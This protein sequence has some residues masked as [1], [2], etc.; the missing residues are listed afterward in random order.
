MEGEQYIPE[1]AEPTLPSGEQ[2]EAAQ[3]DVTP[4]Q[5]QPVQQPVP[6]AFDPKQFEYKYKG[7]ANYPKDRNHLISL[8]SKGHSYESSMAAIK[9][10]QQR[11]AELEGRYKPYAQL[12]QYFQQNPQ[13]K[14]ELLALR[15][16][17]D[18]QGQQQLPQG[19]PPELMQKIEGFENFQKS[20]VQQQADQKLDQSIN[21]VK[22]K[23]QQ[24]DWTTD[25]GEGALDM[26]VLKFMDENKIFDFE[27]GFKAYAFDMQQDRAKAQGMQQQAQAQQQ[28][29][30]M[31]V[32]DTGT[33]SVT[34][35]PKPPPNPAKASYS[36][37]ANQAKAELAGR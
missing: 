37:L 3:A 9:Q 12:D 26:K 13:F 28:R 35:T 1:G 8:I 24:Y 4:G 23:Y 10:E 36:Q 21:A 32:V 11:I 5:G 25:D 2:G 19:L 20:F 15:Q 14:Q 31:G 16:K 22:Q 34:A 33:P 7:Q 18:Q 27:K 6:A 30:R 17:Y 29:N